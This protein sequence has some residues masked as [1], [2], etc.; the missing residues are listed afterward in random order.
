MLL[1]MFTTYKKSMADRA[2]SYESQLNDHP[3]TKP[4]K[5]LHKN[6]Q[7]KLRRTQKAQKQRAHASPSHSKPSNRNTHTQVDSAAGKAISD[8]LSNVTN[9][10]QAIQNVKINELFEKPEAATAHGRPAMLDICTTANLDML[11]ALAVANHH[12]RIFLRESGKSVAHFLDMPM[13]R[14]MPAVRKPVEEELMTKK[15]KMLSKKSTWSRADSNAMQSAA[16]TAGCRIYAAAAQQLK[17]DL[18]HGQ[19]ILKQQHTNSAHSG[20]VFQDIWSDMMAALRRIEA[21]KNS[22]Q[23]CVAHEKRL[24]TQEMQDEG[25]KTKEHLLDAIDAVIGNKLNLLRNEVGSIIELMLI[26]NMF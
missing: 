25:A 16:L 10:L 13:D 19:T 22:L 15:P 26:V 4:S 3:P 1:K 7:K 17:Q 11:R 14:P 6:E 12:M 2:K 9:E 18:S 5:K 24:L 21:K 23:A 20:R 8:E